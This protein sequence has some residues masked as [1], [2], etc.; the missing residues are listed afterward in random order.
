MKSNMQILGI[1]S[2]VD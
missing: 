2:R 1:L